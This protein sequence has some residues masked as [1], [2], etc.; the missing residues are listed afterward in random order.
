MNRSIKM[1]SAALIL[2]VAATG[3]FAATSATTPANSA[4]AAHQAAAA[5]QV[6]A[7]TSAMSRRTVEEMQ[8]ALDRNGAKLDVD[9]YFGPKTRAA[10]IGFQRSHGLKPTGTLNHAT[11]QALNLPH[12]S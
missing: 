10:L 1:L 6:H 5:T 2:S 11:I 7:K 8:T 9:G 3:A 4:L 12:W